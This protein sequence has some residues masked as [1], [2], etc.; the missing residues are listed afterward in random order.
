[1]KAADISAEAAQLQ[2]EQLKTALEAQHKTQ[3]SLGANP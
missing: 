2:H 3:S 1:M